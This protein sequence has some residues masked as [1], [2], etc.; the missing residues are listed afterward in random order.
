MAA[1][2][3]SLERLLRRDRQIVVVALVSVGALAW[4]YTIAG[5]GMGMNAFEMSSMESA[6]ANGQSMTMYISGTSYVL[7]LL[8]MWWVMMVALLVQSAAPTILLSAAL[9]RRST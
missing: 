2:L 8:A 3:S 7:V 9:I 4:L 5:V 6:S 1:E